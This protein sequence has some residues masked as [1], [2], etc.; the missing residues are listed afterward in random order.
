MAAAATTSSSSSSSSPA[1]S[2]QRRLKPQY[3]H[4][5]PA[6]AA[7]SGISSSRPA[8]SAQQ[9]LKPQY[10]HQSP[11]AATGSSSSSRG[12]SR[13]GS[14]SSG[15]GS[16]SDSTAAAVSAKRRVTPEPIPPPTGDDL[17]KRATLLATPLNALTAE[18]YCLHA[19]HQEHER[20]LQRLAY[21]LLADLTWARVNLTTVKNQ[22][23]ALQH[24]NAA[25]LFTAV[26]GACGEAG[27]VQRVADALREFEAKEQD[28]VN[29]DRAKPA[30]APCP[31]GCSRCEG[32]SCVM[33]GVACRARGVPLLYCTHAES[34]HCRVAFCLG[35]TYWVSPRGTRVF[36]VHCY[37]LCTAEC[38][39][40]ELYDTWMAQVPAAP[41]YSERLHE[42]R[43][44]PAENGLF[45]SH[46]TKHLFNEPAAG[47]WWIKCDGCEAWAHNTCAVVND[48]PEVDLERATFSGGGGGGGRR[49]RGARKDVG[50]R[51]SS[52][53]RGAGGGLQAGEGGGGADTMSDGPEEAGGAAA[54]L[55]HGLQQQEGGSAAGR[56]SAPR[57]QQRTQASRPVSAAA[58]CAAVVAAARAHEGAAAAADVYSAERLPR[59]DV[60]DFMELRVKNTQPADAPP[61]AVRLVSNT[62]LAMLVPPPV[63]ATFRAAPGQPLPH[64]IPYSSKALCMFQ[65]I[66]GLWVLCFVM[67]VQEYSGDAPAC[68]RGRA[69]I[70]YIDSAAHWQPSSA[71][72]AAYKE[73][74]V[75]YADWVRRRGFGWIH[76]WSAPPQ[77]GASY[78]LWCHPEHQATPE[79]DMLRRWYHAVASRC[80][81]LGIVRNFTAERSNLYHASFQVIDNALNAAA[82]DAAAA[83]ANADSS[84]DDY[85][86]SDDDDHDSDMEA[87]PISI[88][89]PVLPPFFKGDY[90]PQQLNGQLTAEHCTAREPADASM[91]D[92]MCELVHANRADLLVWQLTPPNAPLLDASWA[93]AA[94]APCSGRRFVPS[95]LL[96]TD[97]PRANEAVDDRQRFIVA[98]SWHQ[99][100]FDTLGGAINSTARIIYALHCPLKRALNRLC[101]RCKSPITKRHHYCDAC[102]AYGCH[103][104]CDTCSSKLDGKCEAGHRTAPLATSFRLTEAAI[105]AQIKC[106]KAACAQIAAAGAAKPPIRASKRPAKCPV[107]GANS[108]PSAKRPAHNSSRAN[109]AVGP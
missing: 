80:Q 76:L 67:Y 69:Y 9:R 47:D 95:Q 83:A 77:E 61:L 90:W 109:G 50:G 3:Q 19:Q 2:A 4:Q 105:R 13:S 56:V 10:Q 70:S 104:L 93:A 32:V 6:T 45:K 43:T 42:R 91:L 37:D 51:G 38:L 75:A 41:R 44:V 71:R 60:G 88:A 36:C 30:T 59:S 92:N 29:Q 48:A 85:D 25:E 23:G 46:L 55:A 35:D 5:S 79:P 81:A 26:A 108:A 20:D 86:D 94:A 28:A 49:D 64:V 87:A 100:Q 89:P 15:S 21:P 101:R 33:C 27:R 18:H 34:P 78:V 99:L 63:W 1:A 24:A 98:Q 40:D 84:D 97:G 65:Q 82:A 39:P 96:D 31:A 22:L 8:A 106:N 66:N 54:A 11:A 72:T 102:S 17:R 73:F 52:E 16:S 58:A 53:D 57:P 12:S 68:N 14:S 107:V 74:V 103:S 7:S 62:K